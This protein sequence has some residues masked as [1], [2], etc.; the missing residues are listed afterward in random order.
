[1]ILSIEK[2]HAHYEWRIAFKEYVH[3]LTDYEKSIVRKCITFIEANPKDEQ[4][5]KPCEVIPFPAVKNH[6]SKSTMEA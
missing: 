4:F 3:T 5:Q 1:L 2:Q 6:Q